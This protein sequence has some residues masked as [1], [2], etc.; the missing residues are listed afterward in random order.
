MTDS[1]IHLKDKVVI[2]TGAAG[3]IGHALSVEFARQG[4]SLVLNDFGTAPDGTGSDPEAVIKSATQLRE[5]RDRIVTNVSDVTLPGTAHELVALAR[6][7]F[8]KVDGVVHCAGFAR[9]R[10]IG[11]TSDEDFEQLWRVHAFAAFAL[12]RAASSAMIEAKQPGSIALFSMNPAAFFGGARQTAVSAAAAAVAG[13]VRAGAAE[14]KR[15][16]IRLNAVAATARTRLT[17]QLPLFQGIGASSLQAKDVASLGT[18]LMSDLSTDVTGEIL[19]VAGTRIYT[20]KTRETPG[21]FGKAGPAAPDEIA[22]TFADITR[23]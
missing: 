16:D 22:G 17:E 15:H 2:V 9:E 4:A 3:G 11:R 20:F 8:G 10:T 21:V 12:S 7:K 1:P 23:I 6:E 13:F 18:F 19:G 14:L 5:A